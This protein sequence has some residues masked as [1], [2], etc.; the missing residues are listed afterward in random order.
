MKEDAILLAGIEDKIRQCLENYMPTNSTFLDMRQRT[1]A[2]ALCRQH[3]ELR[4]CFFGG[5]ED[6]E[7]TVAVF[8]PDYA[9]LRETHPL[10]L[11]RI[12][13]DGCRTLSHRDY[14]GSLMGLGVKR[15]MIGDI[16]ARDGG[17]DIVIMKDMGDFLL[18]HYEKAGR[19]AL[20]AE[21]VSI[22]GI[23]VPES[24][25]D[26]KRDTVASLRLD[27]LIASAFSLSR[28]R[29]AEA[30]ERGMVFVNGLQSEKTD[31]QIKEGDK[32]VVRGK[33]KVL[34]KE[35]VGVTKKDRISIVLHK[36]L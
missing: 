7:R 8:L 12:T 5:Y 19:T 3:K 34:L 36:Y 20:K 11:L 23:I 18:Y 29:A 17:A 26:E 9:E 28:G 30:V 35:V 15:E 14:L 13:Q 4:Y 31:R 22:E 21:L 16:L 25:F 24:R 2:E 10:A 32:L 27:N 1:L 6:A 33:G